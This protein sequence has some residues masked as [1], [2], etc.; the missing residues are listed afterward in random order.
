LFVKMPPDDVLFHLLSPF[1]ATRKPLLSASRNTF[2]GEYL[3]I[4]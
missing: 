1:I 2:F 3:R 4:Q